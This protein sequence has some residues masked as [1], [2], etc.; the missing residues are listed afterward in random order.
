MGEKKSFAEETPSIVFLKKVGAGPM[1]HPGQVT[2]VSQGQHR[3]ASTPNYGQ[4]PKMNLKPLSAFDWSVGG[5]PRTETQREHA[6]SPQRGPVW[7]GIQT[8]PLL[9][10]KEQ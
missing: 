8:Q 4:Q 2:T 1:V 7:W 10:V 3:E 6:N 5:S 9:A